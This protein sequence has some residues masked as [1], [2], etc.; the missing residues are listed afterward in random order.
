MKVKATRLGIE[1]CELSK[2]LEERG[3]EYLDVWT[4]D[5]IS[6]FLSTTQMEM[7]TTLT[8]AELFERFF[9]VKEAI[10]IKPNVEAWK[11]YQEECRTIRAANLGKIG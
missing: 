5:R 8:L 9:V 10:I 3:I 1:Y 11:E 6:T 2:I 7:K 4:I